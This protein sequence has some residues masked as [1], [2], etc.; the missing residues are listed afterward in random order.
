MELARLQSLLYRL[1][2]APSGVEEGLS[3]EKALGVEGLA[4]IIRG[5]ERLSTHERVAI[6]A[7]AYFYRLLEVFKEDFPATLA[8]LGDTH[9][10]NLITGYLIEYPPTEPSIMHAGRHLPDFMRGH[11]L[12]ESLPFI[13][14]LATLERALVE[15]FHAADATPLTAADLSVIPSEQW[16]ALAMR[17]HPASRLLKFGWHVEDIQRAVERQ[18]S[19]Q[20]PAAAAVHILVSRRDGKIFYRALESD[21]RAALRLVEKG[22]SFAAICEAVAGDTGEHDA[23]ARI[24]GLLGRWLGEQILILDR[25]SR[26]PAA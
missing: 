15:I 23:A 16:P 20:A 13:A 19:W 9:F 22:A 21:E 12:T 25:S 5:D 14:D 26:P 3:A 2:T 6:Y 24:S 1:I 7:D 8:V 18:E 10:H 4:A 17:R 11:P